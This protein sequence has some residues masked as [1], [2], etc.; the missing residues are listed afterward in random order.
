[1]DNPHIANLG[2][3]SAHVAAVA[4]AEIYKALDAENN[5]T[6]HSNVASGSHCEFRTEHTA[7]FKAHLQK[8]LK[9]D[10][11]A[12]TGGIDPHPTATGDASR[13]MD[14]SAPVLE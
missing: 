1:M 3:K 13:V 2:P 4:G 12:V 5:I 10:S 6:Y 8:F 7:P 9:D 14:W 11:T